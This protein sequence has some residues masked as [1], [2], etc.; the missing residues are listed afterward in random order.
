MT[1]LFI[2]GDD[3]D[4][5]PDDGES[6]VAKAEDAQPESFLEEWF[7]ETLDA[8]RAVAATLFTAASADV[9]DEEDEEEAEDE[10]PERLPDDEEEDDFDEDWDADFEPLSEEWF[11]ETL[12]IKKAARAADDPDFADAD[13]EEDEE[14]E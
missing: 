12:E 7:A 10:E 1:R 13:E 9:D 3:Y 14:E 6:D 4:D 11:A 8:R 2:D 5:L